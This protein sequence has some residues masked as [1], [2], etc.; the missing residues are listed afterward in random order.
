MSYD[1]WRSLGF[2]HLAAIFARYDLSA[3]GWRRLS[4]M[5]SANSQ[6]L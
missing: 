5:P 1:F 3:G 2:E 6:H 4:Y